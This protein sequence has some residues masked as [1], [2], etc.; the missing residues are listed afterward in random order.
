MSEDAS[1]GSR[2]AGSGSG[3]ETIRLPKQVEADPRGPA[4]LA[5]LL[6]G[7]RLLWPGGSLRTPVARLTPELA[8]ALHST[9]R[10]GRL[11][12]GLESASQT[13]AA[14]QKGLRIADERI[15]AAGGDSRGRRVSRLLMLSDDGA[16]RFYRQVESL[17][18][19]HSPR[20]LAVRLEASATQLSA[21][22]LGPETLTRLLLV[23]HREG[24]ANVLLALATRWPCT[25]DTQRNPA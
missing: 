11:V 6:E 12:R 17:L 20:V 2:P 10:A 3:H 21:A 9:G 15:T 7:G 8:K 24:V 25:P 1:R 23:S 22:A 18:R 16:E 14:E 19:L 5:G 4:L 13:L